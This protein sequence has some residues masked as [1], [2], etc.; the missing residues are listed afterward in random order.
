MFKHHRFEVVVHDVPGVRSG[1][2]PPLKPIQAAEKKV[3]DAHAGITGQ[4]TDQARK[5]AGG[6]DMQTFVDNRVQFEGDTPQTREKLE[7]EFKK[8]DTDGDG[9]MEQDEFLHLMQDRAATGGNLNVGNYTDATAEAGD[10]TAAEAQA[11]TKGVKPESADTKKQQEALNAWIKDTPEGQAWAKTPEGQK[12]LG[13]GGQLAVDGKEGPRTRAAMRAMDDA[14][15]QAEA[16]KSQ[17]PPTEQKPPTGGTTQPVETTPAPSTEELAPCVQGATAEEVQAMPYAQALAAANDPAQLEAMGPDAKKALI[18]KLQEGWT[19]EAGDAAIG[20]VAASLAKSDPAAFDAATVSQMTDNGVRA[21][22]GELS[23]MTPEDRA[24]FLG[25]IPASAREA[26]VKELAGGNVSSEDKQA[27]GVI[28]ASIAAQDPGSAERI[29][30]EQFEDG[31][32]DGVSN[33]TTAALSNAQLAAIAKLGGGKALL[34]AM[35]SEMDWGWTTDAE[36]TQM[37]RLGG[38]LTAG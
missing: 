31:D 3:A 23:K 11:L 32:Q 17:T 8:Y 33:Y 14:K 1:V 7:A 24:A 36:K 25:K 16:T 29:L 35:Q 30:D 4:E 38:A 26:M 13:P 10:L 2:T 5:D 20:K 12:A 37:D 27:A 22:V 21:F 6:F 9:T 18:A 19:D 15:G 28:L 34:E